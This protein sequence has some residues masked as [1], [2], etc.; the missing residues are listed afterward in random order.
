MKG[1]EVTAGPQ[2]GALVKRLSQ[3]GG[4]DFLAAAGGVDELAIADIHA[5]MG[6]PVASAGGEKYQVPGLQLLSFKRLAGIELL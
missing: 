2:I 4:T 3:M 1:S 6:H 5:D